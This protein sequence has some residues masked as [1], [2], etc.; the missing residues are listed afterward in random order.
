V[1]LHDAPSGVTEIIMEIPPK[2]REYLD[3][4]RGSLP[5][6]TNPDEPLQLDSLGLVRLVAFLENDLGIRIEDEELIADNFHTLRQIGQLLATKTP[7]G[8]AGETRLPDELHS[9]NLQPLS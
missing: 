4:R 1:A 2:L 9:G 6:I 8:P 5:P 7:T 3:R